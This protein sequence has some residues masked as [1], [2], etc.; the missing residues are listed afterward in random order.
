M[1]ENI[2]IVA[3]CRQKQFWLSI[4]AMLN[5]S[6]VTALNGKELLCAVTE[7]QEASTM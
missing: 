1:N 4:V 3:G 5:I 6:S 7:T 2:L